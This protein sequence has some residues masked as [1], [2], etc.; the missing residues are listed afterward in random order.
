MQYWFSPSTI[1]KS[2]YQL[3]Y[4]FCCPNPHFVIFIKTIFL[5]ETSRRG[6][7]CFICEIG[8]KC[9]YF[10][11]ENDRKLIP[12]VHLMSLMDNSACRRPPLTIQGLFK[13]KHFP[14]I[15]RNDHKTLWFIKTTV[16]SLYKILKITITG[17][18]L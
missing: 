5:Y 4:S 13:K 18:W 12:E 16:F 11:L 6:V 7:F 17:D 15:V 3:I 14:C 10:K 1:R 9:V 8:L 2:V